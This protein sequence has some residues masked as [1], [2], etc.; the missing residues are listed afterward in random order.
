MLPLA[1]VHRLGNGIGWLLYH[2][3]SKWRK[4][5][6]TNLALCFPE[7]SPMAREQLTLRSLQEKT[8]EI[9]ESPAIWTRSHQR[10][11]ALVTQTSGE[12]ALKEAYSKQHGVILLGAHMGGFYLGNAYLAP[13]YPGTWLYKPQKGIIE[14]L[15][16]EK[17]NAYG[18]NFVP[19]DKTGVMAIWRALN[20]GKV[21]GMSCDHDAGATGGV[22][23]PFFNTAAWTMGLPAKL[24]HKSQAPVYFIFLERLAPGK[25]FHLHVLPVSNAIQNDDAVTAATVMNHMLENCIRQ[26]PEQYD[27]TYKRFRRRPEGEASIY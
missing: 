26:Y 17:R 23:A 5:V 24:A 6:T 3:H 11:L 20:S 25:G 1:L 14:E 18:A 12:Q 8:K 15:S 13:K 16:K 4:T 22:F 2:T 9:L 27:W 19:T 21:A 10:L 7:L